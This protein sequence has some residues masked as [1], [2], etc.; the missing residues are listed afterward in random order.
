[1]RMLQS[2]VIFTN[3]ALTT[4]GRMVGRTERAPG[5][6]HRLAGSR[7]DAQI[8]ASTEEVLT[9]NSRF[10]VSAAHVRRSTRTGA[11]DGRSDR[12]LVFAVAAQRRCRWLPECATG[13]GVY[14]A[15]TLASETTAAQAGS[16]GGYG[17]DP[18]AMRRSSV[19]TSGTTLRTGG[20]GLPT[21]GRRRAPSQGVLRELVRT[22]EQGGFVWPGYAENMRVLEWIVGRVAGTHGGTETF[23]GVAAL[24]G[25]ALGRLVLRS[26]AF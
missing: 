6:L 17:R 11:A 26:D 7:L 1:M 18:F 22:G 5:S 15:A 12:R 19:I 21:V 2:N 10:T 13:T 9:S 23:L 3:V 25:S 20:C 8:G 16:Q 24:R 4:T 14:M